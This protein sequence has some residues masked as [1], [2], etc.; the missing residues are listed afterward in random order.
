MS[1]SLF[2]LHFS[3]PLYLLLLSL[4]PLL[5]L[6][7]RGRS[8]AVILWRTVIFV[9]L[10]LTLADLQRVSEAGRKG[11]RIF[12]FDLSRSIPK[13]MRNWMAQQGLTS[14]PGDRAF[15]FGGEVRELG[16]GIQKGGLGFNPVPFEVRE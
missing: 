5:W 15:I 1:N 7:L 16:S 10:V 14:R 3:H 4:L 8:I 2:S 11:E 6:R 13:E 12:A 9:L